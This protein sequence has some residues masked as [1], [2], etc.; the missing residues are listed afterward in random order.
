MCSMCLCV[1]PDLLRLRFG[2]ALIVQK[3]FD[4]SAGKNFLIPPTSVFVAFENAVKHNEISE[5]TPLHIDLDIRNGQFIISNTLR[6]RNN[7]VRSLHIGLKNL[8]ERFK[9][10]TDQ[11]I[12]S[13]R[14]AETFVV[15]LPMIPLH[16]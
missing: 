15:Q 16:G 10:A 2:D 9:L 13:G 14:K 6:Q 11:G 3:L 7:H 5:R 12:V 8:D 1:K 4:A